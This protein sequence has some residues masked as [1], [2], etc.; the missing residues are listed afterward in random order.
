MCRDDHLSPTTNSTMT[1]PP[2]GPSAMCED[3]N[4]LHTDGASGQLV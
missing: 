2:V 4:H 1:L 3:W